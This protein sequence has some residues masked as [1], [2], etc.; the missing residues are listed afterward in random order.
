L[1]AALSEFIEVQKMMEEALKNLREEVKKEA[2]RRI[3]GHMTK[4]N[5]DEAKDIVKRLENFTKFSFKSNAE[6]ISSFAK[7]M[8]E[9]EFPFSETVPFQKMEITKDEKEKEGNIEDLKEMLENVGY[10][11]NLRAKEEDEN[12]LNQLRK[13]EEAKLIQTGNLSLYG[14]REMLFEFT[15]KGRECFQK[16]FHVTP[17][18]TLKEQIESKHSS[19]TKGLFLYDVEN[20]LQEREYIIEDS[21]LNQI[22]I[23]KG[24]EY[25]HLTL[26]ADE[27]KESAIH[28][29]LDRKNQ[30]KNIG[31]ITPTNHANEIAKK[32]TETWTKKNPTKCKFLSIHFATV[33]N[34]KEDPK[35]FHSM[36]FK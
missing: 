11:S 34:I 5:F 16:W 17:N 12:V 30:L 14:K 21:S 19:L 25:Y 15:E 31:F 9:E 8:F 7:N 28:K 1:G 22:E 26:L 35:I 4:E 24:K 10:N 2:T 3:Q 13:L 27:K 6:E 20:A 32:A 18:P 33:K 29:I 23:S 36:I